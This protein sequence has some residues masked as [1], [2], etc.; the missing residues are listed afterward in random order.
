MESSRSPTKQYNES[1]P[2]LALTKQVPIGPKRIAK[3]SHVMECSMSYVPCCDSPLIIS[4]NMS[5]HVISP[6]IQHFSMAENISLR[7][8]E[9]SF[10]VFQQ[11][12]MKRH[13]HCLQVIYRH[14]TAILC[15]SCQWLLEE[16]HFG[17]ENGDGVCPQFITSG[18]QQLRAE[19]LQCKGDLP[20]PALAKVHSM[21]FSQLTSWSSAS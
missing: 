9:S 14:L 8:T 21:Q 20:C 10:S 5:Y 15:V 18:I 4:I 3:M 13:I 17:S 7:T 2:F 19:G 12:S 1:C 16:A 11:R 6:D